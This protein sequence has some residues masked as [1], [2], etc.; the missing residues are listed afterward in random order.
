MTELRERAPVAAGAHDEATT[1]PGI[2]RSDVYPALFVAV[3]CVAAV[4]ALGAGV[5]IAEST[6]AFLV[7]VAGVNLFDRRQVARLNLSALDDAPRVAVRGLVVASITTAVGFPMYGSL[8][9]GGHP[10]AGLLV[11]IAVFTAVAVAGRGIGYALLRQLQANGRLTG[12]ALIVGAG[13]MGVQVGRRLRERPEYGI[14]PLGYVDHVLPSQP[15]LLPAPVLGD[16][17]DL[18]GLAA[19]YRVRHIFVAFGA[20]PDAELVDVLRACRRLDC[21]IFLVPRLFEAGAAASSSV[22]QLWGLP[23]VRLCRAPYGC[24]TWTVK[25]I[26]DIV[27]AGVLLGLL[28]PLLLVIAVAVRLAI[29]SPVLFRQV[30]IGLN[31]K[32]F[33]LLK[34][35]TLRPPRDDEPSGWS[36]VSVDR[37]SRFGRFL[38]CSSLDELPQLWNVLLGHMSLVGPRPEQPRYVTQFARRHA[39]YEA[40]LRVPAG[41]TGLAQINGLRGATSI[42]DRVCFDNFYIEHWSLWQDIKILIRTPASVVGMRGG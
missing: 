35:R 27:C 5:G 16:I 9:P 32:R 23:L 7:I 21:E 25:R 8:F 30:R 39:G 6:I 13:K 12:A 1:P 24:R 26:L 2:R 4:A 41:V 3:D 37:L 18:P 42:E 29:G 28:G 10:G 34:F 15:H 36:V 14:I 19:R 38:R 22:D 11:T 31:G 17:A 33:E 20:A 40:R